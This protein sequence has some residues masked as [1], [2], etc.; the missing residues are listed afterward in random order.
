M[1][2]RFGEAQITT[3]RF[4]FGDWD[5]YAVTPNDSADLPNGPCQAICV[6][7]STGN[8]AVN[9]DGDSTAVLAIAGANEIYPVMVARVK[10]T[11]TTATGI[12]ALYKKG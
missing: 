10:S 9:L 1:G 12:Y 4:T 11:S 3:N 5:G 7:G 8:V 2:F 6:T